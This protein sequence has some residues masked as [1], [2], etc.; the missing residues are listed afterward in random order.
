MDVAEL[1]LEK[2]NCYVKGV[3][4]NYGTEAKQHLG[5]RELMTSHIIQLAVVVTGIA[6]G[7]LAPRGRD[8]ACEHMARG[9]LGKGLYQR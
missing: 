2:S 3:L 1:L 6:I 8:S 5:Y 4:S 7:G 9:W